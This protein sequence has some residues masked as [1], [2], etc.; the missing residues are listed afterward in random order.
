MKFL[1]LNSTN[2]GGGLK[3]ES[4]VPSALGKALDFEYSREGSWLMKVLLYPN[5]PFFIRDCNFLPS[6]SSLWNP[7]LGILLWFTI[8]KKNQINND[9]HKEKASFLPLQEFTAP[10]EV[11][12]LPQR[13]DVN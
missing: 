11:L 12:W 3:K 8:L 9:P 4:E 1:G 5:Q 10:D 7:V 2:T 6:H 13:T